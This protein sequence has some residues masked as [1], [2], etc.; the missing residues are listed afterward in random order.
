M[1]L[2]H[3][4]PC[5]CGSGKKMKFCKCLEHPQEYDKLLKLIGGGQE[6]AALDRINQMLSKTPNA[7]W[8]LALKGELTLGMEEYE[9]F[10]ET[11][12]RFAKLKP[13][14]PLAL[15]MK[16][17]SSLLDQEPA[18]T[19]AHYLLQGLA[20]SR[21]SLPAM[22]LLSIRMLVNGLVAEEKSSLCGFWA[23]LLDALLSKT[24]G[25]AERTENLLRDPGIN[26][27]AKGQSRILDD[28]PGSP[29]KER[30][31]EVLS[32]SRT[33]RYAQAETKL[34]AILR[35]FPDQAGPLSHLLRAQCAQLEQAAAYAT[36]R[37][38]AAHRELS[39]EERSYYAA[40]ALELEPGLKT[41]S[42]DNTVRYCEIDSD[43]RVAEVLHNLDYA[44][45]DEGEQGERAKH[46]YA[47]LVND[48]VPAKRVFSLFDGSI[49]TNASPDDQSTRVV[50]TL[51][52]VAIFGRQTDRPARVL[53]IAHPLPDYRSQTDELLGL[54]QLGAPIDE[55]LLADMKGTYVDF[56][57]R[58]RVTIGSRVGPVSNEQLD[59]LIAEDFL[60]L[61]QTL[62]GGKT[63]LEAADDEGQKEN[64]LC[65][66]VH[67]EG[68]QSLLAE[69]ATIDE[70]YQ[71]LRL[72]RPRVEV[73]E[74]GLPKL[75]KLLDLERVDV[76]SL[77]A[78]SLKGILARAMSLGCSRILFRTAKE[79]RKRPELNDDKQ[80]QAAALSILSSLSLELELRIDLLRE[81]Q[82]ALAAI[83]APVGQTVLQLISGLHAIGRH[84][85]AQ[86]TLRTAF[87]AHP[88]DPYLLNFLQYAMQSQQAAAGL[89]PSNASGDDL[90][91]RMLQNKQQASA[92]T[93]DSGL[94]IPGQESGASRGESKLW[95]PG[96]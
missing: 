35:D 75:T 22:A 45:P 7:A 6:L 68:E 37:K 64:L 65:L 36:A 76:T 79:L 48:E 53:F 88:E 14:N 11:A 94:V 15:I 72:D 38:L 84:E 16:S 55:P 81:L 28:R 49:K 57:L 59:R 52:S 56:L 18:E 19:A 40:F 29:W 51:G 44:E 67:F 54:L 95:L 13:D 92:S 86:Q 5:P 90:A 77:S 17:L 58:P 39:D 96:S 74:S 87:E 46:F 80:M 41:L 47:S 3:Y 78:Q 91:M 61:P 4:A 82:Q 62:L 83:G 43:E 34:R 8:L 30:L 85:E 63:P 69:S 12:N 93:A 32:L 1:A 10:K 27:I 25:E 26:L 89:H 31:A 42:L 71:R 33:F 66:L 9:S 73:S 23:D 2:D 50:N 70:L 60:H 21:E 24:D 20:E